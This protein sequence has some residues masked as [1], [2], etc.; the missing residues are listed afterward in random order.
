MESIFYFDVGSPYAY[1]T[2]ERIDDVLG[3]GALWV[4][5]LLGG[6]F[7]VV[8]RSSWGQV[9][10][11]S[12]EPG[13]REVEQRAARYGLPPVRWPEPWPNDGLH[14]MRMAA[15]ADLAGAG[16]AFAV[17]M[18]RAAFVDGRAQ[19]DH[20]V[21]DSV[22]RGVDLDPAGATSQAAKDAL[23][24]AT[25]EAIGRGVFGVP[26]VAV[27][28]ELFWGDDQLEAAAAAARG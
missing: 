16:R 20:D 11:Q 23:R 1:L 28:D 3:D 8:G 5:V 10:A 25:D 19:S 13:M 14:A 27:G 15:H 7:R 6:I 24:S 18:M 26:T 22:A 9:G 12:R 2:G 4:P 17:A 21:V